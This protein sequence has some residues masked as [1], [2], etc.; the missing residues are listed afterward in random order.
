LT[1]RRRPPDNPGREPEP[2]RTGPR[3]PLSVDGLAAAPVGRERDLARLRGLLDR[4]EAAPA[5]ALLSGPAGIGK[6]T[7]WRAAVRE[8]H[9]RGFGVLETRAVEAE[10][11][12]AFGGLADL[13][14]ERLDAVAAAL[15]EPQREALDLALQRVPDRGR[16][17]APLAVSLGSL[18]ALR[19]LAS[20]GPVLL[21]V[22]DL[23]WL[24]SA[25]TRVLEYVL[26]RLERE[27]IGLLAAVRTDLADAP[28][29]T[30]A[31][32]FAGPVERIHVGPLDVDAIG[33]L[34]TRVL[35][36]SFRRPALARIH[37]E[38]G[39]NAFFALEIARVLRAGGGEIGLDVIHLPAETGALVGD[40]LAA[41]PPATR[42]P[43]AATAALAQPT[44]ELVE[45]AFP[46]TEAALHAAMEAGVLEAGADRLRFTH[47]LLAAAAYHRLDEQGRRAL[48]GRLA[49]VAPDPEQRARHLALSTDEPSEDVAAQLEAAAGHARARGAPGDAGELAREAA[50]HTP[51]AD[52]RAGRRR[53][54]EA[55]GYFV[56]AG[57]PVRARSLLEELIG[58]QPT[59]D[60]R[61][62]TLLALADARSADDWREKLRLLDQALAEAGPD[63]RLRAAI[64]EQ[65][66]Q[67]RYHLLVDAPGSLADARDALAAAR[68]QDDPSVLCSALSV[69]AFAEGNAGHPDPDALIDE[70]LALAPRVEHRRVFLW[71]A[72]AAAL[73]DIERD[74][75]ARASSR[76][77]ELHDRATALGDWDS[78][79]LIEL[80]LAWAGWRR[81]AWDEALAFAAESER[82]SRQNGQAN[83][84]SYALAAR[85]M[86]EG[87]LGREAEALAAA[88]EGLA[89]TDRIGV[90]LVAGEHHA[91]LG[92]LALARGD[93]A[94]AEAE[95][96]AA[97]EPSL[98]AG[99]LQSYTTYLVPEWGEALVHLG[100]TDEALALVGPYE[101]R[102]RAQATRSAVAA[103]LRTRGLAAAAAG[104]EVA[105]LAAFAEALVHHDAVDAPFARARTLLAQGESLRRFRQ[106][107]RA[108]ETLTRAL[109]TFARLPAPRWRDRV[110]AELG[111]TGHREAGAELSATERQVAELVAAGRTNRE[112][113]E[114]LFMSP[115]TVEAH[116]TRIYRSLGVRGRTEMARALAARREPA[117]AAD[118]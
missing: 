55:A 40:R 50:A 104:D 41:L 99:Y 71:P 45:S 60:E 53:I 72:F 10:A 15:P 108:R 46:G 44:V 87:C 49:A 32:A 81:G 23:P 9:G 66:S 86:I 42:E 103:C 56:Q 105:S 102:A 20:E 62:A 16:V 94:L 17:P 74:R 24:D 73:V 29:P 65:R 84:V 8:A 95:L 101:E 77:R 106:R 27:P 12:L 39:G 35:G 58:T 117:D 26:R 98:E 2:P 115:H 54:I 110:A 5:A 114:T 51:P 52:A 38:S 61:A 68:R 3:P 111:R 69:A 47:P 83:S 96:R 70:A 57:D 19:A 109:E 13:L 37:A 11:Q 89:I 28:L 1:P 43:L 80:N 75:L 34:L 4:A 112:V 107:G 22:D 92:Y 64:L 33:V 7:L 18:A 36:A 100:R 25:T 31:A 30:V 78:L 116:L 118:A 14:G 21:A 59:G 93:H 67:C 97:I 63:D 90:R 79:P 85:G 48:H 82:G 6:T 76:L 91:T 113:A 88:A